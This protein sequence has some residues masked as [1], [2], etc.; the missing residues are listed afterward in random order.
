VGR[1]TRLKDGE[2]NEDRGGR[3]SQTLVGVVS[4]VLGVHLFVDSLVELV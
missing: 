1:D 2:G 3:V 4:L